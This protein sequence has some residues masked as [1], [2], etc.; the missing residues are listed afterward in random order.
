[1]ELYLHSSID[2]TAWVGKF[3]PL[4]FYRTASTI[5]A[6]RMLIVTF[7]DSTL[8]DTAFCGLTSIHF[9]AQAS[10]I[11]SSSSE[12]F[13]LRSASGWTFVWVGHPPN[14]AIYFVSSAVRAVWLLRLASGLW[15]PWQTATSFNVCRNTIITA[16]KASWHSQNRCFGN[17]LCL[18]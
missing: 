15:T 14:A 5:T 13:E 8:E 1:M 4:H 9:F 17:F 7:W 11:R 10:F 3:L 2:T 12:I 18:W 16:K 6:L